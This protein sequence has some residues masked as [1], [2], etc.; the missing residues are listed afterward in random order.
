MVCI[1]AGQLVVTHVAPWD[2]SAAA[3]AA[4]REMFVGSTTLAQ[5]GA[6]YDL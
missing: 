6:V 3:L 4:A 1:S 2:D 5:P